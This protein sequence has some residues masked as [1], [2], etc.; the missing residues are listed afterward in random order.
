VV[1]YRRRIGHI[2]HLMITNL[3]HLL[4]RVTSPL[5][6]QEAASQFSRCARHI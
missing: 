4:L 1:L 5:S 2:G 6:F 3:V